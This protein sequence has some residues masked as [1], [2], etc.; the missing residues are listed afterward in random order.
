MTI[1]NEIPFIRILFPFILGISV[2]L[3]FEISPD[4]Y[5]PLAILFGLIVGLWFVLRKF[6]GKTIKIVFSI[7]VQCF[8]VLLGLHL[9]ILNDSRN[10]KD[11][12]LTEGLPDKVIAQVISVPVKTEK[13]TKV[14]MRLKFADYGTQLKDVQG[15]FIAWFKTNE[16]TSI[17]YGDVFLIQSKFREVEGP[18]NPG[19]FDYKSFLER[20]NIFHT[21]Y[22]KQN[23]YKF[24]QHERVSFFK[25]LAIAIKL[26][27][28]S[29]LQENGLEG[30]ELAIASSLLLGYDEEISK[31]LSNAYAITGTIHVLSVSGLH[32]GI[33]FMVLNLSFSFLDKR[34]GG[35]YTK[36]ILVL[37]GV[38]LFAMISGLSPSVVRAAVMFSLFIF[39]KTFRLQAN[40][41]NTLLASAF[42]ILLF[43]PYLLLDIGFQLSYL[44][45]GGILYFQPKIY[46]WFQFENAFADKI[47]ALTSVSLA[48]Q[49][50]TFP[51]TIYY[52]NNFSVSFLLANLLIIPLSTIIMYGGIFLLI[53]SFIPVIS[54]FVAVLL[55]WIIIFMNGAASFLSTIPGAYI[56][57][58]HINAFELILLYLIIIFSAAFFIERKKSFLNFALGSTILLLFSFNLDN[59]FSSEKNEM[60]IYNQKNN[61][62]VDFYCGNRFVRIGVAG[63]DA[64]KNQERNGASEYIRFPLQENSR[65]Q[66]NGFSFIPITDTRKLIQ[67]VDS[68]ILLLQRNAKVRLDLP[69]QKFPANSLLVSD[70]TNRFSKNLRW[71]NAA[72]S[73]NLRFWSTSENGALVLKHP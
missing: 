41:F 57:G 1:L 15:N 55:K 39:G 42:L 38:W 61:S 2:Y 13:S 60:V 16:N 36:G 10:F 25:D 31:D 22:V 69:G 5:F 50:M 27:L 34:K 35:L 11:H 18:K 51:L 14:E 21:V 48:A 53:T 45:L 8:L 46:N 28:L 49:L 12:Y 68:A 62:C 29:L 23:E 47:W 26:K 20:K 3:G 17:N 9:S 40:I 58:L 54:H 59:Y 33:I 64:I 71:K 52:F 37:S 44:A 63:A 4:L 66:V 30:Q 70:G 32:I 72:D 65:Y 43:D 56:G 67:P 24:L 73:L 7:S 19:A 6:S